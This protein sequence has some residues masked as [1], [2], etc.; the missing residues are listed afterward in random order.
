MKPINDINE[1]ISLIRNNK[2]VFIKTDNYTPAVITATNNTIGE[3][4]SEDRLHDYLY[5]EAMLN[6]GNGMFSIFIGDIH[7]YWI[8]HYHVCLLPNSNPAIRTYS[9]NRI[10]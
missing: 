4:W 2:S 7:H 5:G 9:W 1:L 6:K 3:D 10:K 8:R